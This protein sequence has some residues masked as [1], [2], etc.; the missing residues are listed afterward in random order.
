MPCWSNRNHRT[1]SVDPNF[2]IHLFKIHFHI[3]YAYMYL[4]FSLFSDTF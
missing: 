1:L 3:I 4:F 2:T